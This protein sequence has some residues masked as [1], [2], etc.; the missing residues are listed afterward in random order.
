MELLLVHWK[1]SLELCKEFLKTIFMKDH[2]RN[3]MGSLWADVFVIA[4]HQA[5]FSSLQKGYGS[6]NVW[7]SMSLQWL[8]GGSLLYWTITC[9]SWAE[10]PSYHPVF[11]VGHG[12][13]DKGNLLLAEGFVWE[14]PK[15]KFSGIHSNVLLWLFFSWRYWLLAWNHLSKCGWP[16]LMV[17]WVMKPNSCFLNDGYKQ[18]LDEGDGSGPGVWYCYQ[19]TVNSVLWNTSDNV[20]VCVQTVGSEEMKRLFTAIPVWRCWI[21]PINRKRGT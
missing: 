20:L 19:Y 21:S 6:E 8:K 15:E 2:S 18:F 7:I 14:I 16:F 5:D 3:F 1:W 10:R 9:K 4:V 11:T 12:L 13:S 17:V